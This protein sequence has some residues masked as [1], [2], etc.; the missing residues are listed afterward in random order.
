VS[1]TV[2]ADRLDLVLGQIL[3]ALF[4]LV[5]DHANFLERPAGRV[6]DIPILDG[7]WD[8]RTCG[9]AGRSRNAWAICERPAFW[10]QTKSTYFIASLSSS[11]R[12]G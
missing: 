7:G 3:N 1:G 12:R 8:V 11:R 5:A 9:A 4:D 6:R 2:R 10:V